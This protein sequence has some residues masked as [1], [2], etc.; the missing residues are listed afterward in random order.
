MSFYLRET[1]NDTRLAFESE[2]YEEINV[3]DSALREKIWVPDLFFRSDVDTRMATEEM[4]NSLMKIRKD[5]R[6][7]Y[8]RK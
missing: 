6:I 8:V 2:D 4:G 5:G 7:W 3:E 1:W